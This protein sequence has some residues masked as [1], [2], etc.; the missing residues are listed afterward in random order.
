MNRYR[1]KKYFW[2]ISLF[3]IYSVISIT[4]LIT[5][6]TPPIT[7]PIILLLLLVSVFRHKRLQISN[8]ITI[9]VIIF[10]M[11]DVL[12]HMLGIS[13]RI[14]N[15]ITRFSYFMAIIVFL[16][17]KDYFNGKEKKFIFYSII[18]IVAANI[19]D[20][21]RLNILYPM[22]SVFAIKYEGYEGLNIGTTMFNT[23]SL[24][25]YVVCL[26][27]LINTKYKWSKFFYASLC[28][29][30]VTY[31]LYFGMRGSVVTIMFLITV[32]LLIVKFVEKYKILWLLV[33][34]LA[35]PIANPDFVLD[36]VRLIIPEGRLVERLAD[37]QDVVDEG[38][39]DSSFTGRVRLYEVSLNTY[40]ANISNFLFGIG[41][42]MASKQEVGQAGTGVGGHSEFID[43]LAKWGTLGAI[44]IIYFFYCTYKVFI[45]LTSNRKLRNQIKVLFLALLLCGFFKTIF[46]S[47]IGIV[48]FILLPLSVWMIENEEKNIVRQM[49]T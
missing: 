39:S 38:V 42:H 26:F 5:G 6:M 28:A 19:V 16:F 25:F 32:L 4:P 3:V 44:L 35:I 12:Y 20:N 24:L 7:A 1:K 41:E 33:P 48:V 29:I 10:F 49:R 23:M 14:G 36:F 11:I 40:T 37:I 45:N 31:I 27:M 13:E 34:L 30:S 9:V 43:V 15:A 47:Y 18:I 8:R 46:S 21:I 17:I 2:F 22:A